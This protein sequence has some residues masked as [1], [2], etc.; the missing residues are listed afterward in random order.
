MNSVY[1]YSISPV[2]TSNG[3]RRLAPR[4]DYK[5]EFVL[6]SF[7]LFSVITVRISYLKSFVSLVIASHIL[8]LLP[9]C[10]T[11]YRPGSSCDLI[12]LAEND[13]QN[14]AMTFCYL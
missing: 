2:V 7:S 4:G 8:V 5:T 3:C 12:W 14:I 1:G 10:G 13:R 11:K 6:L 9:R